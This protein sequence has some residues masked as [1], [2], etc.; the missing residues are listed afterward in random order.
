MASQE[1]NAFL[2]GARRS[3]RGRG[4]GVL[5]RL[6]GAAPLTDDRQ[7][8]LNV[9]L[10]AY[11]NAARRGDSIAADVAD[12]RISTLLD[13]ARTARQQA[14]PATP[15]A[16]SFDGGVRRSIRRTPPVDMNHQMKVAIADRD[17]IRQHARESAG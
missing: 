3:Q 2:A 13:E 5:E 10:A 11:E 12:E 14:E 1:M 16:P 9:Q 4:G 8:L 7:D 6:R 15:P 17:A